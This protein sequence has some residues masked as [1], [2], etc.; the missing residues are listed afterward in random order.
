[1]AQNSEQLL[2]FLK[3][4]CLFVCSFN[5]NG[6]LVPWPSVLLHVCLVLVEVRRGHRI[7]WDWNHVVLG[8]KP[9]LPGRVAS[10]LT[11]ES[12]TPARERYLSPQMSTLILWVYIFKIIILLILWEFHTLYLNHI[13]NSS[14]IYPTSLH[15]Q[16]PVLFL[17]P[18]PLVLFLLFVKL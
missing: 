9:G 1:V 10:A 12:I 6:V 14:Q 4:G 5:M 18:F 16:N 11:T 3:N 8:I 13:S 7:S 17:N 2:D 15:T